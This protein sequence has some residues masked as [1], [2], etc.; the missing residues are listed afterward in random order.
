MLQHTSLSSSSQSLKAQS[1]YILIS[2]TESVLLF[3][4]TGLDT[5]THLI[6][7]LNTP[8]C[9]VKSKYSTLGFFNRSIECSPIACSP[10]L[11]LDYVVLSS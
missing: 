4:Q 11:T 3:N 10:Y 1:D 9:R 5:A 2:G 6:T 7:V 8:D